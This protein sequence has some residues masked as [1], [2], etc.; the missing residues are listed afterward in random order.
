MTPSSGPTPRKTSSGISSADWKS[1]VNAGSSCWMSPRRHFPSRRSRSQY[2]STRSRLMAH[3]VV[4]VTGYRTERD[5]CWIVMECSCGEELF[6]GAFSDMGNLEALK[7][8]HWREN[9]YYGPPVLD[10]SSVTVDASIDYTSVTAD[11]SIDYIPWHGG[12]KG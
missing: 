6:D 4:T 8:E 1:S 7:W 9:R 2:E 5:S 11:A 10:W 3:E 12:A